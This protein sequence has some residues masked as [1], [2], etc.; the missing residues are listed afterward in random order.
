MSDLSPEL[1]LVATC[2]RWPPSPARDAAVRAAAAGPID[3]SLFERVVA[4][5]RVTSLVCDSLRDAGVQA[6]PDVAERLA[7][8]SRSTTFKT[9]GM[10]AETV[11]VQKAFDEAGLPAIVLKGATLAVLA[12]D[13]PAIKESWDI[14]LLVSPRDT[15]AGRDLLERLGYVMIIPSGFSDAKFL[16][17]VEHCKEAVLAHPRLGT[18][19]ELHWRLVDNTCI[20]KALDLQAT[21]TVSIGG[22]G[23]RTLADGGLYAY[24]CVHGCNH[25][26]SRLKWLADVGA[27]LTRRS[28]DGMARLH[29]QAVT[30][31]AGRA[32][33]TAILLCH[34]FLGLEIEPE[35]LAQLRADRMTGLLLASARASIGYGSGTREI[36]PYS[37]P[38]ALNWIAKF[39]VMDSLRYTLNEARLNW[40]GEYDRVHMPLPRGLG[41]LYHLL[42]L[43]LWASRFIGQ[44]LRRADAA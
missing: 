35:I 10:M 28:P 9:L 18:A 11:R 32:S 34:E 14:D 12:Y 36:T 29:Q 39:Q 6:A 23:V 3:W 42:R 21:Q 19:I 33:A 40:V 5:H 17:H 30:L 13:S 43:P 26:W 15:L 31:G 41:F 1:A 24:L 8:R 16:R 4:R 38:W 7:A 22:A 2:C 44:K 37:R 25:G 20:L 27:F